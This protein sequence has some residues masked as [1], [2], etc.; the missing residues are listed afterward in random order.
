MTF[1]LGTL[2]HAK[3]YVINKLFVDHRIGESHLPVELLPQGYPP[4]YRHLIHEAFELLKRQNPSPLQV[5]VK[6]TGRGT[7]QHVSLVPAMLPKV[8]ALMNGYRASVGLQPYGKDLQSLL[9]LR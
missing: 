5:T 6:R 1:K 3:G 9:R 7:S 2:L 4:K 8:R